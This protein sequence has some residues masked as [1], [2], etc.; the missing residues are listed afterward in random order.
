MLCVVK[1]DTDAGDRRPAD[2]DPA[3]PRHPGRATSTRR[4]T[5]ASAVPAPGGEPVVAAVHPDLPLRRRRQDRRAGRARPASPASRTRPRRSSS[6]SSDRRRRVAGRP[7]ARGESVTVDG[8]RRSGSPTSPPARGTSPPCR[9]VV[10]PLLQPGQ[11][12][13]VRLPGRRAEPATG[14]STSA[15]SSFM[16]PGRRPPR[17]RGHRR[18]G[19]RVRAAARRDA[20]RARPGQDRLLHQRQ[21]RVPHAADAAPRPGRGRPGRRARA[22]GRRRSAT[23]SRWCTATVSGCSSS[24]TAC[25]TSPG[26]SPGG[27]TRPLRAGRPGPLHR[28]A[29]RDVR[30]R[31]PS[32]AGLQLDVDCPPL[33]RAGATSTR[34]TGRRSC[35]T[36][37]PTP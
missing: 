34:T 30:T 36:W 17:R 13:P 5:I 18:A 9:A 31:P 21:P 3:R 1:E 24:S 29:R 37:S 6:P 14:R 4:E 7:P 11:P 33:P 35:S 23:A 19:L 20:R 8:P 12:A 2:G 26:S 15:T 27:S 32:R 28:R 22:A 16:R 25:S 10:V